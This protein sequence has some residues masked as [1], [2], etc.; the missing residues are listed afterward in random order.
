MV[1]PSW[2]PANPPTH[3]APE[4]EAVA[5]HWSMRPRLRPTNPPILVLYALLQATL[6]P[7]T[8]QWLIQP[9]FSPASPPVQALY[10][11]T[12]ALFCTKQ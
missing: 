11:E 3:L 1:P 12:T 7:S 9:S 2:P 6:P 4:T 5:K 8:P 10:C